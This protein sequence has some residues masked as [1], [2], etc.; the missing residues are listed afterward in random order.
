M[1]STK[2]VA[3]AWVLTVVLKPLP[4]EQNWILSPNK[5]RHVSHTLFVLF[6]QSPW[7]YVSLASCYLCYGQWWAAVPV[8][9][10]N[11]WKVQDSCGWHTSVWTVCRWITYKVIGKVHTIAEIMIEF[12]MNIQVGLGHLTRGEYFGQGQ[13]FPY[14]TWINSW[15]EMNV[16]S[17]EL[18]AV[19]NIFWFYHE[20]SVRLSPITLSHRRM[21]SCPACYGSIICLSYWLHCY[22]NHGHDVWPERAGWHDV[23]RNFAGLYPCSC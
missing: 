4:L 13:N 6:L 9:G 7:C 11:Q 14:P 23:Y 1:I 20:G 12:L 18:Y 8:S 5:E 22:R 16:F 3:S 10:H 21:L 15:Q 17:T 2:I 19:T